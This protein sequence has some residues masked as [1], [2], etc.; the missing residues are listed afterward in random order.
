MKRPDLSK[1]SK[2]GK[3]GLV[4]AIVVVVVFLALLITKLCM[5][6]INMLSDPETQVQFEQWVESLGFAGVLLMLLI[7]VAQVVIA[8]IPGEIV[9]VLAGVMYGTWGGL[10]LCLVGCIIASAFVFVVIRKLGRDFVIRLFGKENID[11]YDFL[12]D[13]SKLET[14]VFILFLIPGLPKDVLT[15][16]VPLT[17]IKMRSFLLLSTIGRIPGMVAST[18]IGSSITDANWPL[19]IAVFAVVIVVGLLCIW[20]KEALMGFAKR[21]GGVGQPACD[22]KTAPASKTDDMA[23]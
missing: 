15:Y 8:F 11:R 2:K 16:I 6:Y 1:M 13:S 12:N 7:Q 17:S 18:L 14:L 19:I 4:I 9:Q 10:A 23:E 20:K 3:I 5:P 21:C 22:V